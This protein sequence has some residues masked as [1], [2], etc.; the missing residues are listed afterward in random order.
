M[1]SFSKRWIWIAAA[2]VVITQASV[3]VVRAL[4]E[5]ARIREPKQPLAEL[6]FQLGDWNAEEAGDAASPFD[7]RLFAA[8]GA[9]QVLERRYVDS[10]G[11]ICAVHL[12]AW[13]ESDTWSPHSPEICYPAQGF[14]QVRKAT[15]SLPEHSSIRVR[16]TRFGNPTDGARVLTMYWYQMGETAYVDR[17]SARAVRRAQWGS[18]ERPPVIKV[19]MQMSDRDSD[20]DSDAMTEL[21]DQVYAF[22]AGL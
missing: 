18:P 20:D 10:L 21:A 12:A 11:R 8:I 22:A 19:L 2:A 17:D 6:P 4:Y 14:E 7:E 5:P 15:T 9:Q 3:V 16:R 13:H 1:H